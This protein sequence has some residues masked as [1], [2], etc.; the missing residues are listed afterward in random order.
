M[1]SLS[2]KYIWGQFRI[3]RMRQS[4]RQFKIVKWWTEI[5]G[6]K[7][8]RSIPPFISRK[9]GR[10]CAAA[11]FFVKT[12]LKIESV[13]VPDTFTCSCICK[14]GN[15]KIKSRRHW[16]KLLRIHWH[17]PHRDDC[18]ILANL[19]QTILLSTHWNREVTERYWRLHQVFCTW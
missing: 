7:S 1:N 18:E 17:L 10:G 5:W 4:F 12:F 3:C 16:S 9:P 8:F 11:T 14:K 6:C 15:G 2:F 19:Y 13:I